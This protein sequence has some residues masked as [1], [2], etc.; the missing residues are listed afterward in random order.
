MNFTTSSQRKSWIFSEESLAA[1]RDKASRGSTDGAHSSRVQKFASGF[2]ARQV[3]DTCGCADTSCTN[4]S[5]D[6]TKT[7]TKGPI[8][9]TRDQETLVQFHAHQ[10]QTL[11]GPY[12]L[13]PELRRSQKVLS[14]AIVLFRR[15]FLSNSVI[16][17]NPRKI[18]AAAALFAAKSEEEKIEVRSPSSCHRRGSRFHRPTIVQPSPELVG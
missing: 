16:E 15:F 14:T 8:L 3:V 11:V 2:H 13:L 4:V 6:T 9:S 1:C 10:I 12:A 18:A 17:C 5:S 7:D